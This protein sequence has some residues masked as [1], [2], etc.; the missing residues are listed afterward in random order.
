MHPQ[1]PARMNRLGLALLGFGHLAVDINPGALPALLPILFLDLHLSYTTA[2]LVVTVGSVTSSLVQPVFGVLS[3]RLPRGWLVPL[4]C[5]LGSGGLA[6]AGLA[7]TYPLLL[8]AVIASSLGV[9]IFHPEATRTANAFAGAR[10]ATGMAL[11]TVGGNFG[12]A[13][14]PILMGALLAAYGRSGT[15]GML[16]LTLTA[17]MVLLLAMRRVDRG[18]ARATVSRPL[19]PRRRG[20][21]ALLI[22]VIF[23]RQW[24]QTGLTTFIPLYFVTYLGAPA[25]V[26]NQLLSALL[27]GSVAGTLVGGPLADRW[28]RKPVVA[29]SLFLSAPLLLAFFLGGGPAA[30]LLLFLAGAVMLTTASVT[31]VMGQELLPRSTGLAAGLTI[32]FASGLAGLG[33][34][35]LGGLA[36]AIGLVPTMTLICLLPLPGALLSLALP[37][38]LER[39]PAWVPSPSG[40]GLG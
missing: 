30:P 29:G 18:P 21:L 12:V 1:P 23:F 36:D 39:A 15:L 33:G 31:V 25:V 27:F 9:A 6:L 14:G 28:G 8:A 5:L 17:P 2:A 13:L 16:A 26:G 11:F 38:T 35:L 22:A 7:P 10:K 37:D 19:A 24:T 40:R 34:A 32:G 3:D 20:A 4:G